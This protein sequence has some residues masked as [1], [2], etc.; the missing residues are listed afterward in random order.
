M[1]G[2]IGVLGAYGLSGFGVSG[3]LGVQR[4]LGFSGLKGLRLN[5][6]STC[7]LSFFM[8]MNGVVLMVSCFEGVGGYS[9][10]C[11]TDCMDF[12]TC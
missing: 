11:H 1:S 10:S 3:L 12:T 9:S 7:L 5:G 8:S 4:G 6:L 2:F